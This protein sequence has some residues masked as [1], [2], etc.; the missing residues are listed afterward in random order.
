[1]DGDKLLLNLLRRRS[2]SACSFMPS[3]KVSP[4]HLQNN[5]HDLWRKYFG[6]IYICN[7]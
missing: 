5:R 4:L 3:A 6:N 2:F 1:L 7:N